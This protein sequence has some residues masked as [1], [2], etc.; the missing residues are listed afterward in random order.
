MHLFVCWHNKMLKIDLYLKYIKFDTFFICIFT[1]KTSNLLFTNVLF[2]NV[3]LDDIL[4]ITAG[5]L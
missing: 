3:K 1:I 5:T 2:A 4:F